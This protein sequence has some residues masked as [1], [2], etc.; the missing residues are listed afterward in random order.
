MSSLGLRVAYPS[1][2]CFGIFRG[3]LEKLAKTTIKGFSGS[4][5]WIPLVI[6]SRWFTNRGF[7]EYKKMKTTKPGTWVIEKTLIAAAAR[8]EL[9]D[10]ASYTGFGG[11]VFCGPAVVSSVSA[12]SNVSM[13]RPRMRTA[14][15]VISKTPSIQRIP[16]TLRSRNSL[17]II[18][19]EEKCLVKMNKARKWELV[20]RTLRTTMP[21]SW[22]FLPFA[23]PNRKIWA[24]GTIYWS[25]P[26]GSTSDLT[27]LDPDPV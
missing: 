16:W 14:L 17:Q 8:L 10:K 7:L 25:Q 27:K 24:K 15:H 1:K 26:I 19:V 4:I 11:L 23:P 21:M 9:R 18:I 6:V 5:S 3:T 13:L 12:S 20:N 2:M 22:I